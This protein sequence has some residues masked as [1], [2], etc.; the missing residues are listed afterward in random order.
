[1]IQDAEKKIHGDEKLHELGSDDAIFDVLSSVTGIRKMILSG[2]KFYSTPIRLGRGFTKS[3]HGLLPVPAPI[4]L[5][6]IKSKISV[7]IDGEGELFT[8][9]AAAI[10]GYYC[11]RYSNF[12]FLVKEI[13]Y[14]AG[15]F[16][17]EHPNVLRLILGERIGKDSVVLL[18]TNLDDVSC[19][20][21]GYAAEKLRNR[22]G[23][24][25]VWILNAIGKKSRPAFEL[26]V[27]AREE[28]SEEVAKEVMK[29]T[30]T[31]G[32]RIFPIYH[33]LIADREILEK[34][35]EFCGKRYEV[36]FKR[37]EHRSKPEFDD[38]ARI[39]EETNIPL[40]KVLEKVVRDAD[41]DR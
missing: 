26:K 36:R 35:V 8:P 23:V 25:D 28:V 1:M 40:L 5:E 29:L 21:L 31:L 13:S 34:K 19:E 33:R 37:S 16:E 18:E 4:T 38:V 11:D 2:Y 30:G 22:E 17:F 7:I 32:V 15:T 20:I 12:P 41:T 10:I 6:L 27:L 3:K 14:G 9:T 39:A 24:L